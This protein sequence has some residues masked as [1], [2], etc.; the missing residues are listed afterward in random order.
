MHKV[1][2]L[3]NKNKQR[4][5]NASSAHDT[6]YNLWALPYKLPRK[7]WRATGIAFAELHVL[8]HTTHCKVPRD[9]TTQLCKR[10]RLLQE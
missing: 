7:L 2:K 9:P 5:C 3:I 1:D 10:H 6:S 8:A 4:T